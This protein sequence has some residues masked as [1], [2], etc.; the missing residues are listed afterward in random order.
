MQGWTCKNE[1]NLSVHVQYNLEDR[2]FRG[3]VLLYNPVAIIY[4]WIR[5]FLYFA[6][7]ARARGSLISFKILFSGWTLSS[8]RGGSCKIQA[9]ADRW[10]ARA[11]F[12]FGRFNNRRAIL[13]SAVLLLLLQR[14]MA[15][16]WLAASA[17]WFDLIYPRDH[18]VG[19]IFKNGDYQVHRWRG[20]MSE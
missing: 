4:I 11:S 17:A 2:F 20:R 3:T 5:Q 8:K 15:F 7:R 18:S 10:R 16:I 9:G 19:L 12:C 1:Q 14:E 13:S 6:V